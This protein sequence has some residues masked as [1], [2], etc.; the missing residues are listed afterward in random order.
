M[1]NRSN[2]GLGQPFRAKRFVRVEV[3]GSNL[4]TSSRPAAI[5][6]PHIEAGHM[7]APD[8]T[9]TYFFHLQKRGRPHMAR[10]V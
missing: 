1:T 8:R 3:M 4:R 5:C 2:R 10:F 6:A 7:A 9:E